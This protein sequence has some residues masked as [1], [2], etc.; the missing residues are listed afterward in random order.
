MSRNFASIDKN[1][2]VDKVISKDGLKFIE[3]RNDPFK[4]YGLYD[5]KNQPEYRRMPKAVAARVSESVD[6]LCY[7]PAGGRVRFSTDSRYIAIKAVMPKVNHYENMC[8]I[9][10][11]G[12]DLYVDEA[13]DAE[14]GF[15]RPFVP[16]NDMKDGYE[17]KLDFKVKKMRSFT[18]N[19]PPYT[20]L[21]D[22]YIGV[23]EDA[24]VSVGAEY[25]PILPVVYYGSSIT[26]G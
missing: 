24:A 6:F 20:P 22:L 21:T 15:F 9:G 13:E 17:S 3:V 19:M 25:R 7:H 23:D 14:C 18:I 2:Q 4:V 12:F 1:F 5:Y 16:P 10:S 8:L 11:S 26:Q